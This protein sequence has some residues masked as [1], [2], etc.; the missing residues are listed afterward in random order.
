MVEFGIFAG[1][2]IAGI[3]GLMI[4]EQRGDSQSAK[5]IKALCKRQR[6]EAL[7]AGRK[8]P[9]TMAGARY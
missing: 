4:W 6:K 9:H 2:C 1:A 8:Y 7:K 3:V 5:E